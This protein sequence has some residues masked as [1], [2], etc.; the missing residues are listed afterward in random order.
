MGALMQFQLSKFAFNILVGPAFVAK[1]LSLSLG[2][3]VQM[4]HVGMFPYHHHNLVVSN[5][6]NEQLYKKN[7][8][9]EALSNFVHGATL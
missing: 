5:F 4:Q 7:S 9:L 3:V 6:V 2:D 1:Y 8:N